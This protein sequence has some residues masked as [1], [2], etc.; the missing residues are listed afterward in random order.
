VALT[1]HPQ[2][3]PRSRC[4]SRPLLSFWALKASST[5]NFTF[6]LFTHTLQQLYTKR[7]RNENLRSGVPN[8]NK[9]CKSG[10]C[11]GHEGIWG[12]RGIAPFILNLDIILVVSFMPRTLYPQGP[13]CRYSLNTKRVG[14]RAGMEASESR[15]IS[16]FALA[17][18][19]VNV[20][21]RMS[22]ISA[23]RDNDCN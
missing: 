15:K 10:P 12:T 13:G 6:T 7:V 22:H 8:K 2:L 20:P 4:R 3:A 9:W 16:C 14:T 21:I 23:H 19:N 18:I 1:T 5:V 11:N 17:G